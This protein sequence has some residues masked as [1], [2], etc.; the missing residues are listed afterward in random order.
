MVAKSFV[1]LRR[2]DHFHAEE[3][4]GRG[5]DRHIIAHFARRGGVEQH[6][7]RRGLEGSGCH[8]RSVP[9]LG[10]A[11]QSWLRVCCQCEVIGC[12]HAKAETSTS[13][14]VVR[15]EGSHGEDA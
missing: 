8:A 12:R 2:G 10:L 4:G 1:R 6:G 11:P 15:V 5:A 3:A 7:G 9:P 13:C 14:A